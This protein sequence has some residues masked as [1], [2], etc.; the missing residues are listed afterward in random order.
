M[1]ERL[2]HWQLKQVG[3]SFMRASIMLV[4]LII[5]VLASTVLVSQT[6]AQ[7]PD[8]G[9]S[10][11]TIAYVRGD[12][13]DEIRLIEADGSNDR[14]LWAHGQADSQNNFAVL[15]L[16][17]RPDGNELAFSSN[18]E[19]T[20]SIFS[21]DLYSL[22]AD[23]QGF[24]RVSNGPQ[25][26]SLDSYPKGA[27]TVTVRNYTSKFDT[28]FYL[29]VHGA[30][31]VIGVVIPWNGVATV[32]FPEVADLGAINQIVALLH[33]GDSTDLHSDY[34]WY[35]GEVDVQA[36]T[37]V[38]A[39]P[40]P[41][42]AYG[43]GAPYFGAWG[44]T[45]RGD[46]SRIG[47][48]RSAGACLG[49]YSLPAGN[50][51]FGMV[52]EPILTAD[53]ISPCSVAWGPAAATANQ[54]IFLA[55]PNLGMDGATFYHTTEGT[56]ASSG[57]RLFSLGST[58]LLLW[59]DWLPNGEG[60]LFVRTTKFANTSFVE[61]NL[62]E[63]NF[64]SGEITQLTNLSDEFVRSFSVSPDGQSIVIERAPSL[65]SSTSD[66]WLMNRDGSNLRLLVANGA[67]PA[68]GSAATGTPAPA[69]GPGQL[70]LPVLAS[71]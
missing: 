16:D 68:W 71:D 11:G 54:V 37:T 31:E 24:R 56:A 67:A 1:S 5:A 45:W 18:H 42:P 4:F 64:A 10:S 12:S 32:T 62:F 39:T 15:S 35:I 69:P 61:A 60:F 21:S 52:D 19:R 22:R 34:R 36:G 41:A 48:A 38:T 9:V 28:L 58:V 6:A 47:Y 43:D 51:P 53:D 23:G 7:S 57:T 49:V 2:N 8:S 13:R 29:Y 14:R 66:L 44:P 25:C 17:W 59:Y 65:E 27:V 3:H 30:P 63:Y 46:G 20:C 26:D 55:Y 50:V 40:N 70:Y 33:T